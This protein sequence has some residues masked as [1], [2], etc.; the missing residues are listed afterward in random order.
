MTDRFSVHAVVIG[1]ILIVLL[2]IGALIYALGV[3]SLTA[4]QRGTV[5]GALVA[6]NSAALGGLTAILVSSRSQ[7]PVVDQAQADA[8]TAMAPPLPPVVVPQA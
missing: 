8:V 6:V 1:L 2:S 5:L 4:E 7:A 3:V